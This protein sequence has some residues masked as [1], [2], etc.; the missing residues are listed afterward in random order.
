MTTAGG[1]LSYTHGVDSEIG[2]LRTVLV[3]R[4]GL[5]LKRITPRHKD[6]LLFGALPWVGRA[7]QEHDIFTQAL[8]DQGVEVLY[9]T[10]LLQDTLEYQDARQEAIASVL[11]DA[12]LG[13]ELRAQLHGHLD[14]LDP[15]A[16]AQV[17]IAGLTPDELRKGRGVV[18][19][20]LDR[21]DF[22]IDPLPNLVFSRDSSFWIGDR[23]GVT[24]LAA[25][26]RRR[27]AALLKII[28]TRHPRF[29]GTK[30]LY[31]PD[32]EQV[33]GG[34]VLLLAPGVLAVGVG[35]RTTPAGLER[36]A[37]RVF[38]AGLAHTVLAVPM[39]QR[40]P[41]GYLDTVCTVIDIDTVVMHPARAFTLIAHTITPRCDGMRVSRP[42]PFLEAAAQ[43]MGIER[44][45]VIDTGVDALTGPREQWD[46]SSNGLAIGR[47]LAVCHER[48]VDTNARLE[49]AG[50]EVIRVPG[51]ELGSRR[52]GPRCMAC[53]VGR[54]P[55]AE[56]DTATDL[57]E[58][59]EPVRLFR[60][61][62]PAESAG[63]V[64]TPLGTGAPPA[65]TRGHRLPLPRRRRKQQLTPAG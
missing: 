7:Q 14:E 50:V 23:V 33:D 30:C 51:S 24:S 3:H 6:R 25:A 13:D 60:E 26:H 27:E 12:A 22:V 35:E 31:G 64:V 55:A 65:D 32:L 28:Y 41:A 45:T 8:R 58:P 54:D 20:L 57:A 59:G 17:L 63:A 40:G 4:P 1:V 44:L 15:E 49:E 18:F 16:L 52:G 37:R 56:P 46:D 11:S 19:E 9:V 2:R 62:E 5:E 61:L 21:H 53:P 42:R 39:D 38:D 47:R 36:L 29:A 43:A 48:N 10:E 34:D